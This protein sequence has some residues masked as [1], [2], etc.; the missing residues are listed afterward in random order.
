MGSKHISRPTEDQATP[1]IDKW[2]AKQ[3]TSQG[4]VNITRKELEWVVAR[5]TPQT[6]PLEAAKLINQ[7]KRQFKYDEY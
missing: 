6:T 5:L 2:A 3:Q 1:H 4:A 7:A